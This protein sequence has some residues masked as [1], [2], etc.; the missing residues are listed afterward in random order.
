MLQK[1]CSQ[2]KSGEVMDVKR[3]HLYAVT[4]TDLGFDWKLVFLVDV[5]AYRGLGAKLTPNP[6]RARH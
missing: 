2:E 1:D 4:M 3:V 6:R 5:N